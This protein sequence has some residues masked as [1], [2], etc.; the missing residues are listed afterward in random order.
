MLEQV[1]PILVGAIVFKLL[2]KVFFKFLKVGIFIFLI[3]T[4]LNIL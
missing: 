1:L 2:F 3:I 4:L